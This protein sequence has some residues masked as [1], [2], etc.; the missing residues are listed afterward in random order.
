VVVLDCHCNIVVAIVATMVP[1]SMGEDDDAGVIPMVTVVMALEPLPERTNEIKPSMIRALSK[2]INNNASRIAMNIVPLRSL[3]AIAVSITNVT[4]P[5]VILI[6]GT[7]V[8]VEDDDTDELETSLPVVLD[9]E[10]SVEVL[11][12]DDDGDTLVDDDDTSTPLLLD[13]LPVDDSVEDEET[14]A[15]DDDD[16]TD[17]DDSI[18]EDEDDDDTGA[19]IS[20][21]NE[22][23]VVVS[24][25]VTV[26]T[27]EPAVNVKL[28][29]VADMIDGVNDVIADVPPLVCVNP[30]EYAEANV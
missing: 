14:D 8:P 28:K 24:W 26:S 10:T 25:I 17:D 3:S 12:E 20:T 23:D 13:S 5:P 4:L 21:T 29:E 11:D 19:T 27:T 1:A 6:S 16:T 15:V 7:E 2:P 18:V 9:D 30:N 22:L